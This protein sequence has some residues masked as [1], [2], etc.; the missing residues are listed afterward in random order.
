MSSTRTAIISVAL[1]ATVSLSGCSAM[2]TAVKKRNLE[3]GT[4]M[5]ETIWLDPVPAD[6]KTIYLQV[7]N[8]TDK[9]LALD[10]AFKT[11]LEN[12]GYAVINNPDKAHYWLQANVLK[13]EK[14][15]LRD[16]NDLLSSGYGAALSGGALGALAAA[17]S[18]NHSNTVV[19]AGLIGAAVG[20]AADSLVEDVNFAMVTDV[21]VVEKTAQTVASTETSKLSNGIG[22]LSNT[23]LTRDT[24]KRRY[25]TR[26][27]STANKVNLDFEEAK[28]ELV[29]NLTTSITG[30]F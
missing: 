7:R 6:Q 29:D 1:A 19:G 25:Q 8:T 23:I 4:K 24:D 10:S 30:L 26:V 27:V 3:V 17:S 21:R 28:P 20:F 14:M 22:N 18:T 12:K 13:L 2:K 15:D 5:S 9:Q 11:K 16:A